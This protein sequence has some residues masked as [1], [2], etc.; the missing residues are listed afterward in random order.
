M[1]SKNIVVVAALLSVLNLRAADPKYPVSE[2]PEELKSGVNAIFREDHLRFRILSKR[3]GIMYVH[4]VITI[5]NDKGKNYAT[6]TVAYDKLSKIKDLNGV[7]YDQDGKQLKKLKNSQI[8]DQSAYESSTLFSDDRFKYVD[9]SQ[10]TYPYTVEFDYEVEYNYLFHI[11]GFS[12]LDEENMSVV[13]SSYTLE[14]LPGLAPRYKTNN[15]SDKPL[16]GKTPDGLDFLAWKFSTVKPI[17]FEALSNRYEH[18]S[19]ISA[20]PSQFE[21]DNYAG[22]MN[23]W[24]EFGRWII[25]LNTGR[26]ELPE[27]VKQNLKKLTANLKTNEEKVKAVYEYLQ[28]RT[29][30]VSIQLG[31]GGYQP[32]EA[33]VV[34]QTGYGDCKAL[35]N[36]TIAMLEAIGIKANYVLI[37]AG[38]NASPIET[39]F[40]S[41]QFNH[42]IAAVPNGKDTLWLECTSQTNPFGYQG[43]FTGDRKALMITDEGAKIVNT[44]R[45]T[46]DENIQSRIANVK[47][48]LSGDAAAKIKTTYRGLEYENGHLN[49]LLQ[50]QSDD[51]K[52]WVQN[53]TNIP[54]F[55]VV[56]FEM[57]DHRG[58]IPSASVLLNLSLKRYSTVSGKRIFLAPNL[59]N[60]F[61]YVPEKIDVR[62][63]PFNLRSTYTHYDTINF[64]LPEGIYPEFLPDPVKLSSRFGEYHSTFTI[65][66]GKLVY[67]RKLRMNK[68]QFLPEQYKEFGEFL[69][70][71][72][73]ADNTKVVFLSKT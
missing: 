61:T 64:E 34:D 51:Q 1:V 17:N 33:S 19:W 41:T 55:D 45:Y 36:Y 10:T 31:I 9:L 40:P 20:A 52:K 32:F 42:A 73:K 59:M 23:T 22:S 60:K 21:Y 53:H 26:R 49:F 8:Y 56:S 2:I 66:S 47:V 71:I 44:S 39:D 5:L 27:S 43:T 50:S 62:K 69:K 58:K 65:E 46:A 7:V 35:S 6:K 14:F 67:V 25:S 30:Y 48:E 24:D 11:P 16:T 18:I 12:V 54:S 70:S 72:N 37:D 38:E 4:Q 13:N 57:K 15:I 3:S 63:T 68:G 28:A 29:R